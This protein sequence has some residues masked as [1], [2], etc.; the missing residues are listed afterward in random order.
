[1]AH[2][3]PAVSHVAELTETYSAHLRP[4]QQRGLAP[5]VAGL[6]AAESGCEQS[7]VNQLETLG[8]PAPAT[9]ASL[10]EWLYDGADRAAPCAT[11]LDLEGCFAPGWAGSWPG[12]KA[13]RCR[14]PSM[15]RPCAIGRWCWPSACCTE[16]VPSRWP[17][18]RPT[19]A[20][21]RGSRSWSVC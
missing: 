15:P 12:G 5:W 21:G 10:R 1:V 19:A 8:L 16:D 2:P 3:V 14:W 9:R 13:T 4:A 11:S 20:S 18:C 7:I 6:L 17:G